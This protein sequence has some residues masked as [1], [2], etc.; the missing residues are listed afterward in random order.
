MRSF[1][2]LLAAVGILAAAPA[3]AAW[4]PGWAPVDNTVQMSPTDASVTFGV[5]DNSDPLPSGLTAYSSW[6]STASFTYMY[7]VSS[8]ESGSPSLTLPLLG[9]QDEV[10]SV[11]VFASNTAVG[12]F[13]K[14]THQWNPL[15]LSLDS[16]TGL[17]NSTHFFAESTGGASRVFGFTS[18]LAPQLVG[19]LYRDGASF[20]SGDLATVPEPSTA[21]ALMGLLPFAGFAVYR[22][23]RKRR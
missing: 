4:L 21:V 8:N 15:T 2:L 23:F 22:R 5:W 11:G 9:F 6:D 13:A 3:Q 17:L 12:A 19:A 18:D 16:T 7:Q 20:G 14:P 1:V 10:T